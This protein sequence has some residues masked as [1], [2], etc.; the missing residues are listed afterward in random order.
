MLNAGP[1]LDYG[2]SH[3]GAEFSRAV[4]NSLEIRRDDWWR[5][6]MVVCEF[7]VSNRECVS[8][9]IFYLEPSG[10]SFEMFHVFTMS[11]HTQ[12]EIWNREASPRTPPPLE[13]SHSGIWPFRKMSGGLG[14]IS[15]ASRHPPRR[16]NLEK[17]SRITLWSPRHDIKKNVKI[18]RNM[19]KMWRN[20][21]KYVK[22]MKKYEGIYRKYE[23]T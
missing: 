16:W 22:N 19:W 12:T 17:F 20:M 11:L 5:V 10:G 2:I 3:Q 8:G 4:V 18:W 13:T 23:E 21:S 9:S 1:G 14:K 15:R 7:V 6:S